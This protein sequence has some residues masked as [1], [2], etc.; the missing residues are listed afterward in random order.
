MSNVI[1]T[2]SI[3]MK[4]TKRCAVSLIAGLLALVSLST[5]NLGPPDK[6]R[7]FATPQELKDNLA[8]LNEYFSIVS[9]PRFGRSSGPSWAQLQ[10][11]NFVRFGGPR[12]IYPWRLL[13]T[14]RKYFLQDWKEPTGFPFESTKISLWKTST[15]FFKNKFRTNLKFWSVDVFT[16]TLYTTL[17]HSW[18]Q[19]DFQ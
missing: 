14:W 18:S 17:Y 5:A 4:M 3:S 12:W 9:R 8:T 1:Q 7:Y 19:S 2:Q 10:D 11:D 15:D 13:V 6:P 16:E